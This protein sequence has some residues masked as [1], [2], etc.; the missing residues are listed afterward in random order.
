MGLVHVP[1]TLPAG[2]STV[3]LSAGGVLPKVFGVPS[4]LEVDYLDVTGR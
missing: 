3:T 1:V 4:V 2:S